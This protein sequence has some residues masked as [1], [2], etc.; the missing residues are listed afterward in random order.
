[1][2]TLVEIK[3][4]K[5]DW[6][7]KKC[8]PD[9]RKGTLKILANGANHT[10]EWH[11]REKKK[12]IDQHHVARDAYLTKVK[13]V[14]DGRVYCLRYTRTEDRHFFWMQDKDEKQDVELVTKF[15]TEL[16]TT[17]PE[18]AVGAGAPAAPAQTAGGATGTGAAASS[19]APM[20]NEQMQSQLMAML[21]QMGQQ[22][23]Q[24]QNEGPKVMVNHILTREN[25]TTLLDDSE[26]VQE[27][28]GHLPDS[29]REVTD[30]V[31]TIACPQLGQNMSA[32]SQ[33][34]FSDQLPLLMQMLGVSPPGQGDP[35]EE[36][37]KALENK[38]K[39]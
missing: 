3:M 17:L 19:G 32:L 5:L 30:L 28:L 31:E 35:M 33:A 2:A 23:Q 25:M 6:D 39:Q 21:A 11:D 13:K 7:G 26:L 36:L 9:T 34:I 1:M 18:G 24:R 15:N 14:K 10:V 4:G 38:Y 37:C 8:V 20:T 22:N 29:Q 16:K 12:M 27:L